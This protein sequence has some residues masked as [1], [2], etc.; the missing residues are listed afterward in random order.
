MLRLSQLFLPK[1]EWGGWLISCLSGKM[2]QNAAQKWKIFIDC[3]K[4][5]FPTGVIPGIDLLGSVCSEKNS[6]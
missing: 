2:S 6:L 5:L 1:L 3:K 4:L